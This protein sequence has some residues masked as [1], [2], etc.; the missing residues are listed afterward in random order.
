MVRIPEQGYIPLCF[1]LVQ[2]DKDV[3]GLTI[4]VTDG[5]MEI[6][7][8]QISSATI[9]FSKADNTV[10][11]GNLTVG[12]GALTYTMGTNEI[13]CPG[14]VLTSIQLIGAANER[15]T[16]ARF[17]FHVVRDLIIPGTVQSV[18]EFA[19][20]QQLVADVNQLKQDIVNLQVPDNSLMDAKLSNTA[21]QIKTRFAD[22]VTDF[23]ELAADV[24]AHSADNA[25]NNVHGLKTFIDRG[26]LSA[27]TPLYSG[28]LNNIN[29]NS[30]YNATG[31]QAANFPSDYTGWAFII[32]FTHV[33]SADYRKQILFAMLEN[34][35]YTRSC[36]DGVWG[37]WQ[38]I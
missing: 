6:D 20:L 15:L 30:I 24:S 8:S 5:V 34:K 13:A 38:S 7:Y 10:V 18:S 12:A 31:E 29:I 37:S 28:D 32:T 25:A 21:G 26:I 4:H 23:N 9:A 16:T 11:Q 27:Q 36:A 17:K 14:D 1:Q 22:H 19:I 33:Y 35:H 3:Y 2:N